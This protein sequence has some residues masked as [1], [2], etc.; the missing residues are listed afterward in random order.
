MKSPLHNVS[1][2]DVP[3]TVPTGPLVSKENES[4]SEQ[5]WNFVQQNPKNHLQRIWKKHSMIR[6]VTQFLADANAIVLVDQ[7][8]GST[9]EIEA[10]KGSFTVK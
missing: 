2:R 6:K 8:A 10:L 4:E 5:G 9:C 1:T 7:V 3:G